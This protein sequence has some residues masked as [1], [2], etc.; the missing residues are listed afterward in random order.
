M[1]KMAALLGV[2]RSGYYRYRGKKPSQREREDKV[3]G[4]RIKQLF[5]LSRE[6]YGSDRMQHELAKEGVSLGKRRIIRLMKEI[7]L[8][9]KKRR[10]FKKTTVVDSPLPVA[11]NKLAQQFEASKPNEKWVADISVPQQAV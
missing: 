11:D 9:P 4:E 1:E 6:T 7:P 3:Y 2:S 8:V 5:K 10:F